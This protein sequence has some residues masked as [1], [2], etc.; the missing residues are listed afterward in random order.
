MVARAA[1]QI[2]FDARAAAGLPPDPAAMQAPEA[3]PAMP[4]PAD[5]MGATMPAPQPNA[6]VALPQG[7]FQ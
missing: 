1:D 3:V 4:V 2:L 7:G 6:P 5:P